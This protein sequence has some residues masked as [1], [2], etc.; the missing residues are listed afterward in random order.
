MSEGERTRTKYLMKSILGVDID[1]I[2]NRQRRDYFS[3]VAYA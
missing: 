1:E 2:A 3:W